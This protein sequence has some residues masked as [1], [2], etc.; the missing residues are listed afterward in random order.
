MIEPLSF[1]VPVSRVIG[2]DRRDPGLP[3][4]FPLP[5]RQERRS[6]EMGG[7]NVGKLLFLQLSQPRFELPL[8]PV[9]R[10]GAIGVARA[11]R[12]IMNQPPHPSAAGDH[13]RVA[14]GVK[15][16][17]RWGQKIEQIVGYGGN[18]PLFENFFNRLSGS[19]MTPTKR[20]VTQQHFHRDHCRVKQARRPVL[21]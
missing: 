9:G 20:G 1:P 17:H 7:K 13:K 10:R 21:V 5:L 15:R 8:L 14:V 19:F 3:T 2:N 6:R 4:V 18:F 12:S 16:T 11:I